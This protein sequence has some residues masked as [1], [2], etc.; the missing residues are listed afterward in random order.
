MPGLTS[1]RYC[2]GA[3]VTTPPVGTVASAVLVDLDGT[4]CPWGFSALTVSLA[5]RSCT[6]SPDS[7]ANI[8]SV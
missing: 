5:K 8:K 3:G 7:L 1:C 6:G 4:A 2:A